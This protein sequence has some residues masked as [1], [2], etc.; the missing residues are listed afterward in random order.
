M[1]RLTQEETVKLLFSLPEDSVSSGDDGDSSSIDEEPRLVP[2]DEHND[3]DRAAPSTGK[4][5]KRK[6]YK[7]ET[8]EEAACIPREHRSHR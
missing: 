1:K 5:R 3:K 8:K 6:L 7:T 2:L 4:G